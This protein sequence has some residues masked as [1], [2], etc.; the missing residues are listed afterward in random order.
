MHARLFIVLIIDGPLPNVKQGAVCCYS[1]ER[2]LRSVGYEFIQAVGGLALHVL[3][4]MRVAIKGHR[5]IGIA[6]RSYTIFGCSP[7]A[8]IS[9]ALVYR[10]S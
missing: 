4:N 3:S 1:Q 6:Y 9:V 10:K 2:H 8:S 5:N 7:F